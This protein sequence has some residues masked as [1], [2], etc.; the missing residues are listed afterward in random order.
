MAGVEESPHHVDVLASS[1]RL[2]ESADCSQGFGPYHECRG[3]HVADASTRS[4]PSLLGAEV[5]RGSSRLV[6]RQRRRA[7]RRRDARRDERDPRVAEMRQH[8]IEPIVVEVD[9]GID[10]RDERGADLG[11][12][13]VA[14]RGRPLVRR[15]AD[16]AS[17]TMITSGCDPAMVHG[18][19]NAGTTI[20][21]LAAVSCD[22]VG[23][24]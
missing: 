2:V 9:V 20:V 23:I 15:E 19:L 12:T 14:R 22:F 8:C 18:T 11:E 10:E 5:E 3:R 1:Q 13:G 6:L 16:D 21:T 7:N 17:S 24:G 4:D